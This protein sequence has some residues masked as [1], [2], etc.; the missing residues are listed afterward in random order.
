MNVSEW[1]ARYLSG[2][3]GI[4]HVY[5]YQGTMVAWLVD[6]FGR[7]PGLMNHSCYHEQGAAFAACGAA[8][9]RGGLAC[10]YSTSGPGAVNLLQG[11]ANAYMDS[12]PV[13][14]LTGQVNTY[15]Y[16][17]IPGMRQQAFQEIDIVA[18]AAPVTKLSLQASCASDAIEMIVTACR[19][20]TSG[21]PGPVL[22]DLPMDVQRKQVPDEALSLLGKR[23]SFK[24]EPDETEEEVL[25]FVRSASI[26][27]RRAKRPILMLGRGALGCNRVQ[28]LNFIERLQLPVVTS[29][30]ARS[31]I[32]TLHPL[33]IGH[34]GV[35]YG[36]RAANIIADRKA[37]VVIC[38]GA[39]LCTR[40][41]GVRGEGDPFA[42]GAHVVRADIDKS[43][44]ERHAGATE[45]VFC[46]DAQL[47][48]PLL[49]DATNG[50]K[51]FFD[52]A[53]TSRAIRDILSDFD[54][55]NSKRQGNR[56]MSAL[57]KVLPKRCTVAVDVGQHMIWASHSLN[58][59]S[60]QELVFSGGHGAMGWALPAAIGAATQSGHHAVCIAGDGGFQMNIQELQWIARERIPVKIVV[61]NNDALG[62]IVAC[63]ESY[64]DGR[65][66]GT[67]GQSGYT[68]PD[69]VSIARAYGINAMRVKSEE[70]LVHVR[71]NMGDDSPFLLEIA[72]PGVTVCNP[73]A[74]M[75][76]PMW[77][78]R[79]YL[80]NQLMMKIL[81]M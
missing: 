27:L 22:V 64:L 9:A 3:M 55:A 13:L 11:I 65:R 37:D 42:C 60:E 79:P 73:K 38:L 58:L 4:K 47:A 2:P 66:T 23:V 52:W 43:S 70:G 21:R 41:V 67:D 46:A 25:D 76:D 53:K 40:Q 5:G 20:A 33:N 18:M 45:E 15:E 29:L 80:P 24:A 50:Y 68:T 8:L 54:A 51:P 12:I 34:V 28:L 14:F 30:P 57:S 19:E 31:I 36:M 1:I 77:N 7:C 75:G 32:P 16:A 61:L 72:I 26:T 39:S 10:A 71:Q 74:M 6:A 48:L 49:E 62:M 56:A 69:F 17:G 78:Q 44:F 59:S 63:Q 35:G 81:N